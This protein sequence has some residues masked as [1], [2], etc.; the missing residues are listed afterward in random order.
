[1]AARFYMFT[2]Y[3]TVY[4]NMHGVYIE[5]K[6]PIRSTSRALSAP[7]KEHLYI[8]NIYVHVGSGQFWGSNFEFQYFFVIWGAQKGHLHT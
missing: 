3:L 1:M 5:V 7:E 6:D 4:V 2:R 8:R